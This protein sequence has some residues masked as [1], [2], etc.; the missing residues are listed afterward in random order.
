M[1]N[2]ICSIKK[3]MFLESN[4]LDKSLHVLDKSL[5]QLINLPLNQSIN[6]FSKAQNIS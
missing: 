6:F 2:Q 1:L 5:L 4:V 3:M